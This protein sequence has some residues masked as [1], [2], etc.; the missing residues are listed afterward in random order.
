MLPLLHVLML[1]SISWRALSSTISSMM[2]SRLFV[3]GLVV[4]CSCPGCPV[5]FVVL[6]RAVLVSD[7]SRY[8]TIDPL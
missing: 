6:V 1:I 2:F 5:L 4:C 3:D 7:V 8:R